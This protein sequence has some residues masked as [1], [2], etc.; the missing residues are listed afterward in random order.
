[1][2]EMLS[3]YNAAKGEP[4]NFVEKLDAIAEAR[5]VIDDEL[6]SG[7][8][9]GLEEKVEL[10]KQQVETFIKELKPYVSNEIPKEKI[11]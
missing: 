2:E 7:D 6:K 8:I 3:V 1:M 5:F 4:D 11:N 9:N 10:F